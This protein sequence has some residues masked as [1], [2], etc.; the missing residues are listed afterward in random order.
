MKFIITHK[1]FDIPIQDKE[2]YIVLCPKGTTIE[3]WP[4]IIYFDSKFDNRIWSE[5]SAM[6]WIKDN[7]KADFITI[8][9]YRRLLE[10]MPFNISYAEPINVGCP[11]AK[12]YERYHNIE[13]L[14]LCSDIIKDLYPD[15]F[16]VWEYTLNS[17]IFYPYNMVSFP[18]AIYND[19]ID[20]VSNILFTFLDSIKVNN[21][22]D[23]IKRIESIPTYTQNNNARNTDKVYQA[24]LVSFLAERIT[25]A[26]INYLIMN[27]NRCYPAKVHKYNKA[28]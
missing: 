28:F 2:K 12:Q 27:N 19:Y 21:Y 10:N 11:I 22:D 25:S 13:D 16:K 1:Q 26:Y 17:P 18:Q 3:N 8:N 5:L 20:K 7:I 14:I 9:H 24:R 6:F 23:M 4:E 15:F